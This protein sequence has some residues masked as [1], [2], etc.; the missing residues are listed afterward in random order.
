MFCPKC[1]TQ[2]EYGKFCRKCGTNLS[3]VSQAIGEPLPDEINHSGT[4]TPARIGQAR[5]GIT[6]GFFSQAA[7]ANDFKDLADHKAMAV[8][9]NVKVDLTGAPLPPG[10]THISAYSL[11]GDIEIFVPDNVGVRITG[12]SSLAE[13]K[14]RGEKVG[15][16]FFDVNEYRSDNY[17]TAARRLHV[18][19]ASLL[20]AI[21]I[22]R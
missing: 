4:A 1:G 10:E 13:L 3:G 18:E 22:R 6:V 15:K 11:F 16:G 17:E 19:V 8:F 7:I 2:N 12:F 5:G 9:G 21:K 14:L 20:S